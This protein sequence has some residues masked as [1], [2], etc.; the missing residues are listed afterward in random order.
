[1]L[2]FDHRP[3][4]TSG[5][6]I[7][8]R[9]HRVFSSRVVCDTA[10][11]QSRPKGTQLIQPLGARCQGDEMRLRHR[12][13]LLALLAVVTPLVPALTLPSIAQEAAAEMPPMPR[14]RPD[15]DSLPPPLPEPRPS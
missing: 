15:P 4:S 11:P 14:P 13:A 2:H 5:G 6:K 7:H 1:K 3:L 12:F 9:R 10:F 8:R